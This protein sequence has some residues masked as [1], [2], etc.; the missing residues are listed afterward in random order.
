MGVE[1][2]TGAAVRLD[3]ENRPT[4]RR[5]LRSVVLRPGVVDDDVREAFSWGLCHLLACALHEITGWPF[6][7]LEQ[8]YAT[9]AW[10]WVH[11]A[12]ITPDGLLLDV[13]G[14]RHW[15]EAEAERRHFGGEFRL[16]NVPTFAELYRM[17]GLPD[18]T[19][20]TWWRGE[21]SDP[22]PA[23]IMRLAR[24]VA[25]RHASTVLEVA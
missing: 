10:S 14:A 17:F 20:D 7:V 24:D 25:S 15:R 18:G 2:I 5:G 13:H 21:F 23:A 11:A 9:G 8:S 3:F 6:G 16:V 4:Q 19:P 22:G 12:V 1:L